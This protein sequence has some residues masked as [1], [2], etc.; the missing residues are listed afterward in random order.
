MPDKQPRKLPAPDNFASFENTP[1]A[2]GRRRKVRW[3]LRPMH[4]PHGSQATDAARRFMK[5][6]EMLQGLG[7]KPE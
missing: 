5:E 2:V 6:A 7:R 3:S 1:G 4:E